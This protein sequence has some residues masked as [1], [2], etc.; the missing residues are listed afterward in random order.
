[1]T[2]C[3]AKL[4]PP[5]NRN[6]VAGK[7]KRLGIRFPASADKLRRA[8]EAYRKHVRATLAMTP[9]RGAGAA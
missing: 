1:M 8:G 9:Y 7:A 4:G 3:A 6:M 2:E 5:F